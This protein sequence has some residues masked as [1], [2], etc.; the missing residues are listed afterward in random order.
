MSS[1]DTPLTEEEFEEIR[2]RYR[3]DYSSPDPYY[4][5]A[6]PHETMFRL[7]ETLRVAFIRQRVGD[8]ADGETEVGHG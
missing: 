8:G 3:P 6:V 7:L 1:F 5:F 4:Q 2:R